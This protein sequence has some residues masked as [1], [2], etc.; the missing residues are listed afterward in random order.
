M[1]LSRRP[2]SSFWR[3]DSVWLARKAGGLGDPSLRLKSGSTLDDAAAEEWLVHLIGRS[4]LTF[5]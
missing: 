4:T 5:Q 1:S 2:V 3:S